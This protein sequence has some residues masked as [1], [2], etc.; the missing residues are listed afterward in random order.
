MSGICPAAPLKNLH[1]PLP[2][3]PGFVDNKQLRCFARIRPLQTNKLHAPLLRK[4]RL[5]HHYWSIFGL[6]S[7][8]F[9]TRASFPRASA[10]PQAPAL[11][12]RWPSRRDR[13]KIATGETRGKQPNAEPASWRDAANDP[14]ASLLAQGPQPTRCEPP[15]GV[16]SAFSLLHF[17]AASV[18]PLPPQPAAWRSPGSSPPPV[19]ARCRSD[20]FPCGNCLCLESWMLEGFHKSTSRPWGLAR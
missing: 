11:N 19:A 12:R 7:R 14:W 15:A 5:L 6:H 8:A 9:S 13:M 16:F 10:A 18:I 17:F 2:P 3:L 20:P 4:T 1:P